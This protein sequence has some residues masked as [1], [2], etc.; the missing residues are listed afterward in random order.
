MRHSYI[1]WN[2][3]YFENGY[4][5]KADRPVTAGKEIIYG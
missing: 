5:V 2:N 4:V 3:G 1:L